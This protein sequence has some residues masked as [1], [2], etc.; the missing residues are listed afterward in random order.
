MPIYH[1]YPSSYNRGYTTT[2][3]DDQIE[4]QLSS[5]SSRHHV[6]KPFWTW[7][8]INT[9]FEP[10]DLIISISDYVGA[11][12]NR[13]PEYRDKV[14]KLISWELAH[15]FKHYLDHYRFLQ[16]DIRSQAVIRH[17]ER[18]RLLQHW[19]NLYGTVPKFEQDAIIFA[20]HITGINQNQYDE[21]YNSLQPWN[22]PGF[23]L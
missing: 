1:A 17:V 6:P 10:R 8:A 2:E 7:T 15:E 23:V 20:T 11:I 13:R 5:L 22:I 21:L 16:G 9:H 18:K 3:L 12:W 19:F 4:N 14:S